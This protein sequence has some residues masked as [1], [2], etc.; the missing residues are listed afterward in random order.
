MIN[1]ATAFGQVNVAGSASLDGTL[2]ILL[3]SGYNP[4]VGTSFTFLLLNP[5]QLSGTYATI[6]NDIFNGGTEKWLVNYNDAGGFVSLTAASNN[7]PVP[8]A[9]HLPAAGE[10]TAEHGVRRS[11]SLAEVDS[12]SS[13]TRPDWMQSGRFSVCGESIQCDNLSPTIYDHCGQQHGP[14]G[15]TSMKQRWIA[16]SLLMFTTVILMAGC[17][18][19]PTAVTFTTPYQAVLLSNNSVYYGKLA[20]YG[21][22]QSG[23]DRRVLHR[24]PDQS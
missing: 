13:E 16:L 17:A 4:A 18:A 22:R 21:T 20:G 14:P 9:G 12:T 5:G 2:D 23:V 3:Q 15:R 24:Q 1:S 8:G 6:L 10:R 7:S 11:P 19:P